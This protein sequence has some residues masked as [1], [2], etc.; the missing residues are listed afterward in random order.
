MSEEELKERKVQ[1]SIIRLRQYQ[2]QA[3][4]MGQEIALIQSSMDE[5]EKA[6]ITIKNVKEM[7]SGAE[8]IVP[9]GATSYVHA[10][11]SDATRII[12]GLGSGVSAEKTPDNAISTLEKRIE[13]LNSRYMEAGR[14]MEEINQEIQKLQIDISKITQKQ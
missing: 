10:K 4:V 7:E 14:R 8:L 5:H 6:I 9:I 2:A 11:L 3:E 1:E 13:D 12:I